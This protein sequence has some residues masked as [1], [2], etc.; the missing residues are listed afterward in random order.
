MRNAAHDRFN[1]RRDGSILVELPDSIAADFDRDDQSQGFAAGVLLQRE[2]LRDA[3][4][5]KHEVVGFEGEDK[6][7]SFVPN[8]C[9]D[10]DQGGTSAE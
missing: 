6:L 4:V 7:A 10:D 3:V 2:F 8:E 5:S 9:R 1:H